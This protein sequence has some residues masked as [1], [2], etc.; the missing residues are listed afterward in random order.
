MASWRNTRD[1]RVWRIKVIRRDKV[2][3]ICGSIKGRQ[4]HHMNSASYFPDERFDVE[5]G[6]C[7]CSSCHSMFHNSYK[8]S[9]RQKCTKE[10]FANFLELLGKLESKKVQYDKVKEWKERLRK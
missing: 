8:R 9:Y 4:A 3:Q 6:I 5:N 1:Y 10:D 2:C 7:L